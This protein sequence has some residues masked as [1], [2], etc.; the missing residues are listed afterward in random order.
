MMTWMLRWMMT[1]SSWAGIFWPANFKPIIN[2]AQLNINYRPKF[3]NPLNSRPEQFQ[4]NPILIMGHN[5]KP[6]ILFQH[7][8]I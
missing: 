6:I 2:S 3:L 1:S 7:S 8:P 5:F 4:P